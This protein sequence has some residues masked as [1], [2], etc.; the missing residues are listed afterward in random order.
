M[1]STVTITIPEALH[2]RVEKLAASRA[3]SVPD[4]LAD[5]V[6]LAENETGQSEQQKRM[7][8]EERAYRALH[9]ELLESNQ[10]AFV[11]IFQGKL[12]DSDRDELALLQRIDAKYP[13][14]IVLI[15]RVESLPQ[16][17]LVVRS[18]RLL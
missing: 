16:R 18:P 17:P 11:A 2:K 8:R 6:A 14:E 4:L 9:A 3:Q 1:A 12:V 15:K 7:A 13:D 5:A 10:G